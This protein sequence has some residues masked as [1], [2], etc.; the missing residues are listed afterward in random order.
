MQPA[1]A[2]D[3]ANTCAQPPCSTWRCADKNSLGSS[4][5][6]QT[7][8]P[9]VDSGIGAIRQ[10]SETCVGRIDRGR[11][12]H[13]PPWARLVNLIF[14][15]FMTAFPSL[16]PLPSAAMRPSGSAAA[17]P[18][19]QYPEHEERAALLLSGE[20]LAGLVDEMRHVDDVSGSVHSSTSVPP[21]G[22][23]RKALAARSTGC[24]QRKPR[25]SRTVSSMAAFRASPAGSR[26]IRL[27]CALL[28]RPRSVP[29][30]GSYT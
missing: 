21:I 4:V 26:T 19:L 25:R 30:S 13:S 18:L 29:S 10:A 1:R 7:V 11:V 8:S 15:T 5:R 16:E 17:L 3:Y 23:L 28:V 27:N 14:G 22:T 2:C 9:G 24:G 6:M 12:P 20:R